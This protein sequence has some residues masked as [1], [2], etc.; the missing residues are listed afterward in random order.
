MYVLSEQD[1]SQYS[2]Y[3]QNKLSVSFQ[4]HPAWNNSA[5]CTHYKEAWAAK[6][7]VSKDSDGLIA[8]DHH[9]PGETD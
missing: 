8:Q 7:M 2:N 6:I 1:L 4:R 5:Q 3:L 9:E